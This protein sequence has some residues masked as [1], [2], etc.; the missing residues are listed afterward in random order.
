MRLRSGFDS[1]EA[2]KTIKSVIIGTTV[3]V[4]L[5]EH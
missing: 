2:E 1:A 4:G 5:E 3:T